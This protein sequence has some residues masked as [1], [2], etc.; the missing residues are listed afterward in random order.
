MEEE[1]TKQTFGDTE[2]LMDWTK[3]KTKKKNK[4]QKMVGPLIF[5]TKIDNSYLVEITVFL[6]QGGEYRLMPYKLP[7]KGVCDFI[8]SDEYFIDELAQNSNF[9]DP[10]QCPIR[11]VNFEYQS[12]VWFN[13]FSIQKEHTGLMDMCLHIMSILIW[14]KADTTQFSW[15]SKKIRKKY[16]FSDFLLMS[17]K[18]KNI[19]IEQ[20]KSW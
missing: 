12:N 18:Y 9:S 7:K 2:N 13:F 1:L 8:S 5:H 20:K 17:L 3:L 14:S 4:T 15:I 11:K 19:L 6:K 16:L 10:M